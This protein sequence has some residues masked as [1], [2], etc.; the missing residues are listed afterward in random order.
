MA[1]VMDRLLLTLLNTQFEH[2]DALDTPLGAARW[3]GG[4]GLSLPGKPRFD[5]ALCAALRSV[6][7]AL[8]GALAGKPVPLPV[9]FRGDASD[10]ILFEV[11]HAARTIIASG[12]L[13]RVRSCSSRAC[14]RYFL[15]RT[16]NRSRRWCS[17]RCMERARAPRRRTIP[18]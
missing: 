6:R 5:G 1:L 12:G 15:D 17:L 7:S 11:L 18:R 10:G 4:A 14:G 2:P 9:T 13:R 16:K 3:W 8:D